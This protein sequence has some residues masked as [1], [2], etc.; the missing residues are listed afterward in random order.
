MSSGHKGAQFIGIWST[1]GNETWEVLSPGALH[2]V[3]FDNR[4]ARGGEM[5]ELLKSLYQI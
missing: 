2:W 3:A 5:S 1:Y 4:R